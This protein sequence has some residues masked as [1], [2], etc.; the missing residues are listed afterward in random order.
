MLEKGLLV[1]AAAHTGE[2]IQAGCFTFPASSGFSQQAFEQS[3]L[4]SGEAP[5]SK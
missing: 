3:P 2:K 4:Q 1:Q 5:K